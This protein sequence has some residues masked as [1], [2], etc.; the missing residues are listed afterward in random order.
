MY[1]AFARSL[2]ACLLAGID[3]T[4]VEQ[5]DLAPGIAMLPL[6][7]AICGRFVHYD[8]PQYHD[9]GWTRAERCIFAAFNKP[10]VTVL[11]EADGVLGTPDSAAA[12]CDGDEHEHEDE[13]RATLTGAV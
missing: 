2:N 4:C 6:Y 1:C 9:R 12:D 3:F 10:Q 7:T 5:N 13:E 8:H 11:C